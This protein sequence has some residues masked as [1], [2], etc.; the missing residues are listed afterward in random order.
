VKSVQSVETILTPPLSDG[1]QA[2]VVA[3]EI[4]DNVADVGIKVESVGDTVRCVDGKVQLVIDG[5]RGLSSQWLKPANI[6]NFRQHAS[7]SGGTGNKISHSTG[8]QRH[9]RNK[10]FVSP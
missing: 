7:K 10:V 8:G 6:H 5:A 3:K 4:G 2:R 1:K 9:R